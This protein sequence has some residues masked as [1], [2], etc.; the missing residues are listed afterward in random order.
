MENAMKGIVYYKIGS[1]KY[2]G[3]V[4]ND[5]FEGK[6]KYIYEDG[7]YYIGE[8]LN[9]KKHGKGIE[10]YKNGSIKYEGIFVNDESEG[11]GKYICQNGDYYIDE[12]LNGK[13]HGK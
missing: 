7:N 3:D 10:Y 5:K 11:K 4:F 2:E 12:W 8:W 1:I 13:K 6:G 9:G